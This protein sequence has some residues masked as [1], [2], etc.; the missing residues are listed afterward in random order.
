[1][2]TIIAKVG[3]SNLPHPDGDTVGVEAMAW[4]SHSRETV[5]SPKE[6]P[7]HQSI[8]TSTTT[9]STASL[10]RKATSM[11]MA[12][13]LRGTEAHLT[14]VS[15]NGPE[16]QTTLLFPVATS[17]SSRLLNICQPSLML[18]VTIAYLRMCERWLHCTSCC[19]RAKDIAFNLLCS[20]FFG[21]IITGKS[22]VR[23]D[24]GDAPE[25]CTLYCCW[26]RG[27]VASILSSSL[28]I[29][30]RGRFSM[31]LHS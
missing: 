19:E 22:G 14:V 1:M 13:G 7:M 6:T 12:I 18:G 16:T 28:Y 31:V 15:D 20:F 2:M 23:L 4:K 10:L 8:S 5:Q 3:M 29:V 30:F 9:T 21:G 26:F 24:Y 17:T 25:Y 27:C 11:V